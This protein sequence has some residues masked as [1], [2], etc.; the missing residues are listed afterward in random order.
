MGSYKILQFGHIELDNPV[1][2]F[3]SPTK[4]SIATL[5]TTTLSKMGLFATLSIDALHNGI[6]CRNAKCCDFL[7]L[8]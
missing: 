4:L 1:S 5:S 2:T 8:C 6:E 7:L 3:T